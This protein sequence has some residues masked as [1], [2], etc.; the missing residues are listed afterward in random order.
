MNRPTDE[1]YNVETYQ[2]QYKQRYCAFIDVLG[3]SHLVTRIGSDVPV[4][5]VIGLLTRLSSAVGPYDYEPT[6]FESTSISDAI[7]ISTADNVEG[8]VCLLAEIHELALDVLNAGYFIRGAVVK[9]LLYHHLNT[10][11]GEALLR[12]IHIEREIVRYPR[13]LVSRDVS[14][15]IDGSLG[16]DLGLLR[17]AED[18]PSFLHV[19]RTYNDEREES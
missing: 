9:G 8:L 13:V 15:Q 19:L 3:F 1:T 17:H 5:K 4:L 7:V 12:A 6:E 16:P 18:G 2:R 11:V 10:V 14:S